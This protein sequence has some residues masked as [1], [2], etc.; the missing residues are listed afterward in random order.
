MTGNIP[1]I[2]REQT[3]V[4]LG[5]FDDAIASFDKALEIKPDDDQAW[6]IRGAALMSLGNFD[7]AFYSYDRALSINPNA[8][9]AWYIRACCNALK[10]NIELAI[11]DLA[12]AISL[13]NKYQEMAKTD[14]DFDNLR[15]H[16]RFKGLVSDG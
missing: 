13:N 1:Y 12:K 2:S 9:A 11:E 4:L 15:E 16:V 14:S 5:R 10:N 8:D 3:E 6:T 7:E